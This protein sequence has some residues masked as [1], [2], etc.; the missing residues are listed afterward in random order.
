MEALA[1]HTRGDVGKADAALQEY[2]RRENG[3]EDAYSV[4]RIHAWRGEADEMF[5][6]LARAW[7]Q[8]ELEATD[9]LSD[10]IML[11]HRHDPRFAAYCLK[12][13]LP[14]PVEESAKASASDQVS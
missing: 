3:D 4:A 11:P 5:A 9:I 13:G 12:V 7:K 14:V 6:W 2:L 1:W 10:P 8:R